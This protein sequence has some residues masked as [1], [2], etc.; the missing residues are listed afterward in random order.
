MIT[1]ASVIVLTLLFLLG[2]RLKPRRRFRLSW[3]NVLVI[4]LFVAG[5]YFSFTHA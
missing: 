2:L 5:T 1:A 4:I 3:W